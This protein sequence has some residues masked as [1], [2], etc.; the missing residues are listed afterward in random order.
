MAETVRAA[1]LRRANELV[2]EERPAPMPGPGEVA[3]AVEHC[4]VCGSDVHYYLDGRIGDMVVESPLVLGHEFAGTV[5]TVGEGV[6][7]LEVGQAVAVQ[8]GVPCGICR[9]CRAGRY[10]LCPDVSFAGTP[11]VDGAFTDLF[12]T[13]A[14]FVYPL[15]EGLTTEDGALVEPLSC[16]VHA[17]ERA[18]VSL[19]DQVAILGSGPIGLMVSVACQAAGATVALA[20]DLVD[21]RLRMAQEMGAELIL[22]ATDADPVAA[23]TGAWLDVV[24]D[25]AGALETP[26]QGV[27]MVRPGGLV[28]IVGFPRG[29]AVPIDMANAVRKELTLNTMLRFVN[30]VPTA[31]GLL[32]REVARLRKLVTHR[33]PF[34]EIEQAFGLVDERA[35]G[36]VKAMIVL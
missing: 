33:F 16:G 25:C 29:E 19:G 2:Y 10:N 4:G 8:P 32:E 14:D 3:V 9:L 6:A 34:E 13:A 12:V 31:L 26:Q 17:V 23:M 30:N 20:T 1:V 35:D 11:P 18:G 24:F 15:P 21:A 28:Q 7:G 5:A 27:D 36:V 22:N